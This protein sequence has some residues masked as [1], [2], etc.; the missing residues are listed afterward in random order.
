MKIVFIGNS[1]VN[2]YPHNRDQCFVSLYQAGTGYEVINK[3]VNGGTSL[4]ILDRFE[5]DVISRRPDRVY[6]LGG[7]ND[8]IKEGFT[9][10][11]T[12]ECYRKMVSLSMTEN[13]S[14]VLMVPLMIDEEMVKKQWM[15]GVDY[16]SVIEKLT[17]L[18]R[19]MIDY[20]EAGGVRVLD[21][22]SFY[23]SLY[24]ENTKRRYLVDGLHPTESGHKA[25]ADFLIDQK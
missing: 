18:R 16:A 7:T 19:L 9:A 24:T 22:Q 10:K 25:L 21:T 12:L 1:I 15:Q 17:D 8:F 3:G 11:E 4:E 6:I 23:S 2:G 5:R 14:V 13:I 20:G